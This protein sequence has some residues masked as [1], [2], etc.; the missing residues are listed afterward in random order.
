M[1]FIKS[2]SLV[3][4]LIVRKLW[5]AIRLS[6]KNVTRG[7][8]NFTTVLLVFP[9]FN[10]LKEARIHLLFILTYNQELAGRSGVTVVS[11]GTSFCSTKKSS[12]DQGCPMER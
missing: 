9:R 10:E 1:L 5:Y 11:T 7:L 12:P 6:K 3:K 4:I 8:V 2:I